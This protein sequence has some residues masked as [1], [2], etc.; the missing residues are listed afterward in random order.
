[1]PRL[2]DTLC[3]PQSSK[4]EDCDLA[5]PKCRSVFT[6]RLGEKAVINVWQDYGDGTEDKPDGRYFRYNEFAGF[7]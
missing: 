4:V 1:M 5:C 2:L 3:Q 6:V 7:D